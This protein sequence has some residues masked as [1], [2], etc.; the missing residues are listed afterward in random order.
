MTRTGGLVLKEDDWDDFQ[1]WSQL[2]D[3][4]C[5]RDG[6]Y[7]NAS[8]ASEYCNHV[9]KNG[10]DNFDAIQKNLRSWRL[11]RHLPLRRNMMVLAKLLDVERDPCLNNRWMHLYAVARGE[12][13]MDPAMQQEDAG[14]QPVAAAEPA[15]RRRPI[16]HWLA[17]G[18]LATGTGFTFDFA[19]DRWAFKKLPMIGYD[20]RVRMVV[21]ESRLIHGD[22]GDCDGRPPDWY[23]TLPRVPVSAL[24]TFSDGG[25][26]RKMSNFCNRVVEVRAV[27]FT[28]TDAGMEEIRLLD[29]FMKIEVT[30]AGHPRQE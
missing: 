17:I 30:G 12:P 20:A 3:V 15:K 14:R 2:F 27:R 21:G 13:A 18:A 26:A 9:G 7:D 16:W 22:R 6:H 10:R 4:L 29:D 23:Y 25:L 24:G 19:V 11:G 28:A 1:T 8:L 5:K